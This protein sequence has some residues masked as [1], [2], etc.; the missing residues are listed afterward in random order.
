MPLKTW[1]PLLITVRLYYGQIP[2]KDTKPQGSTCTWG[3]FTPPLS[4]GTQK[5]QP[6][7]L[8]EVSHPC[9]PQAPTVFNMW[10]NTNTDGAPKA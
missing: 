3:E 2:K 6:M 10:H 8:A 1:C 9:E 5:G 4:Q 7:P